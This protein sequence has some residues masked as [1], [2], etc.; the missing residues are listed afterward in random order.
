[1]E[2]EKQVLIQV[3]FPETGVSLNYDAATIIIEYPN[4]WKIPLS[5]M[6]LDLNKVT[7]KN[8]MHYTKA[9]IARWGSNRPMAYF[10]G[11]LMALFLIVFHVGLYLGARK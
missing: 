2:N 1:M 4:G 8:K 3:K 10:F 6:L 9:E 11:G 7:G 5:E